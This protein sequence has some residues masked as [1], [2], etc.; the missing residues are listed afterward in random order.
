MS[1]PSP[2]D[3]KKC[4]VLAAKTFSLGVIKFNPAGITFS[5]VIDIV[6]C[7]TPDKVN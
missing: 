3:S 7:F 5:I 1:S 2:S 6:F 4:S